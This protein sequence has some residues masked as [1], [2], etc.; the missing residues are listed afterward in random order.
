MCPE[1]PTF[2]EAPTPHADRLRYVADDTVSYATVNGQQLAYLRMKCGLGTYH[3]VASTRQLG[4]MVIEKCVLHLKR[5][6]AR[7]RA[8]SRNPDSSAAPTASGHSSGSRRW[9]ID[10]V[11]CLRSLGVTNGSPESVPKTT[12]LV[13]IGINIF[14][15]KS[16]R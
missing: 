14:R 12:R 15:G 5:R 9:P 11:L 16:D 2:V 10:G 8:G 3:Q 6:S 13:T 7:C 4:S 1:A